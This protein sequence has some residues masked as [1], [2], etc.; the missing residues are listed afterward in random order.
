MFNFFII[1]KQINL[2]ANLDPNYS[3]SFNIYIFL[4][5]WDITILK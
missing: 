2:N 3:I 4:T 5:F 1:G